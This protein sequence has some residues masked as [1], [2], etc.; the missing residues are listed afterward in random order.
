MDSVIWNDLIILLRVGV[1]MMLGAIVGFE[2]ELADKP[3]GLRT[4][5]LVAG[6][7]ALVV[8]LGDVI[9]AYFTIHQN[10][11]AVTQADPI[12]LIQSVIIGVSFLGAGTIVRPHAQNEHEVEGLTTAASVLFVSVIGICAGFGKFVLA[13]GATLFVVVTV[14]GLKLIER[15]LLTQQS[16]A[17]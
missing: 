14:A 16:R 17:G 10:H 2:R 1:A 15:W 11:D 6:S 3:A 9:I 7:A 5:M 13:V 4:H 8:S 12:R